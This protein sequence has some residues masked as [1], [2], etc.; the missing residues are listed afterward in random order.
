MR[1]RGGGLVAVSLLLGACAGGD[2]IYA[3]GD[4]RA[5][6]TIV[7]T[8]KSRGVTAVAYRG[9]GD[10]QIE[11]DLEGEDHELWVLHYERSLDD[12]RIS[13]GIIPPAEEGASS[14]PLPMFLIG[15]QAVVEDRASI[16]FEEVSALS[17]RA[18]EFRIR[19]FD[20]L[21]CAASGGCIVADVCE[22][23]CPPVSEVFPPASPNAPVETALPVLTPCPPGWMQTALD[24]VDVCEPPPR[25]ETPCPDGSAQWIDAAACAPIV[26]CP[27][28]D[29]PEPLPPGAR[30]FVRPGGNGDGTMNAPFGTIAD[31][32]TSAAPGDVVVLARGRHTGL[33]LDVDVTLAGAC[34]AETIVTGDLAI[35]ADITLD[36]LAVEGAITSTTGAALTLRRAMVTGNVRA[37]GRIDVEAVRV[38]GRLNVVVGPG[39]VSR[40]VLQRTVNYG[41]RAQDATVDLEDVAISD[42]ALASF[43]DERGDG[44]RTFDA[45]VTGRRILVDR[46]SYTGVRP[47]NTRMELEDLVVRETR[48]RADDASGQGIDVRRTSTVTLSRATFR[49]NRTF[50]VYIRHD[51]NVTMTDVVV[52]STRSRGSDGGDGQGLYVR[53]RA[54]LRATRL[55]LSSNRSTGAVIRTGQAILTDVTTRGTMGNEDTGRFGEGIFVGSG[56]DLTL[57]RATITDNNE[58]GLVAVE[59]AT[60][61]ASDVVVTDTRTSVN[62]DRGYG[63]V[64]AGADTRAQVESAL[65]ERCRHQGVRVVDGATVDAR[66]LQVFATTRDDVASEPS[67]GVFVRAAELMLERVHIEGGQDRGLRARDGASVGLSSLSI[68]DNGDFGLYASDDAVVDATRVH[69]ETSGRANVAVA[70]RGRVELDDVVL[71]RCRTTTGFAAG[72]LLDPDGAASVRHFVFRDNEGAGVVHRLQGRVTLRDGVIRGHPVGL[73]ASEGLDST[74]ISLDH[75]VFEDNDQTISVP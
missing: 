29:W 21:G 65:V 6:A 33:A 68:T 15:R 9:D 60:M 64:I 51:A 11:L 47:T 35:G 25:V 12:L 56:G 42:I 27:A 26:A 22:I 50:A 52:A 20:T 40:A 49:E 38:D 19:A 3:P 71:E 45:V 69:I 17:G 58:A 53:D 43:D 72:L 24:G 66:D 75:V 59:G 70:G 18:A 62:G 46:A 37:N 67:S 30:W 54:T 41:F 44:I 13:E 23:P 74:D 73:L 36:G 16:G 34:P 4:S 5:N 61:M 28:G 14:R 55:L 31:A 10:G 48:P 63:I 8:V 7:V 1:P 39:S 32:L 57:E 2:P